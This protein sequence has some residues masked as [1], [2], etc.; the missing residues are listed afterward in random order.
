MP[1]GLRW[2]GI[3]LVLCSCLVAGFWGWSSMEKGLD[4]RALAHLACEDID[5]S[6]LSFDWSYRSVTV[7]GQLPDGVTAMQVEQIIDSGSTNDSCLTEANID[8]DDN[9]GVRDVQVLAAAGAVAVVTEQDPEPTVAPG[10]PEPVET[11]D[12]IA[13][14]NASATF[15]GRSIALVGVVATEEQRQTLVDAARQAVGAENVDDQL[16]V[17]AGEP[18]DTADDR[19]AGLAAIMGSFDTDTILEGT[20]S[21]SDGSLFYDLLA[22]SNEARATLDL[23]GAGSVDVPDAPAEEPA[24]EEPTPEPTEEPEPE[25]A[26]EDPPAGGVSFTG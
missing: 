15:D 10:T 2:L 19:V 25:P 23:P 3:P 8:P 18:S 16:T 22:A 7:D 13:M 6:G 24:V 17:A 5:T 4:E 20:A 26:A 11:V 12:E 1:W 21:A 14:L 9:P